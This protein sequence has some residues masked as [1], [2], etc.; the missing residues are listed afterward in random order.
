MAADLGLVAH[1]AQ[2]HAHELAAGGAGDRLA[3][4]GLAG[5]GRPDQGEDRAGALVLLD[6]AVLPQLA[7]GQVLGDPVLDV[8]EPGVVGV[9]HLAGVHGI[10]PLLAARAPGHRDQPVEVGADHRGLAGLLAHPLE[11]AELALGLLAHAR[12]AYRTPRSWRGTRPRSRRRPR[13]APCGSSPSACAG[14]TRA[15][16]SGRPT[17]R[18]RGC[19]GAPAPARAP[20]AAARP[21][22]SAARSRPAPAAAAASARSRCPASSPALSASAPGV[23]DRAQERG[24]RGRRRRAARASPRPRRGTRCSSS[25][26]LTGAGSS[27]A[28][29]SAA[30]RRRPWASVS[31]APSTARCSAFSET[32]VSPRGSRASSSTSATTPTLAILAFV[33]RHQQHPLLVADVDG[34]GDVHVREDDG[35]F[36]RD[37]QESLPWLAVYHDG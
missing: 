36:Q 8:L 2:R 29:S 12:R 31:A 13:P 28:C 16:A 14:S 20:R 37:E 18:R 22:A 5:A 21:P 11:P 1:A 27:S 24:R 26:V 19:A 4:R 3:D 7:H 32:A 6:A 10:E 9:Q 15:A 33:G 17:R 23:G 25:R 35:V 34:Q 30:T